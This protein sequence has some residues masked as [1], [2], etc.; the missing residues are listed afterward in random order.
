M[1]TERNAYAQMG[2]T[3]RRIHYMA[4]L[5]HLRVPQYA[6]T[7]GNKKVLKGEKAN[8]LLRSYEYVPILI[9][10]AMSYCPFQVIRW[11]N[12]G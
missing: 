1:V 2:E 3:A 11:T 4:W 7:T 9:V 10:L 5:R 12:D 8:V 6:T